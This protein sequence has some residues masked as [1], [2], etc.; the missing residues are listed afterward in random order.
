MNDDINMWCSSHQEAWTVV[1]PKT[2]CRCF[3][4]AGESD[5]RLLDVE[6]EYLWCSREAITVRRWAEGIK[7]HLNIFESSHMWRHDAMIYD[8]RLTYFIV[9]WSCE[10][11]GFRLEVTFF[12][13]T[14][15]ITEKIE[16]RS[17]HVIVDVSATS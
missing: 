8:S 12:E 6:V 3:L 2:I 17:R 10:C 1:N 9:L 13:I 14:F 16:I 11:N 15:F 4:V 7:N 5:R